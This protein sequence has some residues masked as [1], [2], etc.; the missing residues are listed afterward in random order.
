MFT[1]DAAY[2]AVTEALQRTLLGARIRTIRE[3]DDR[4][5]TLVIGLRTQGQNHLLGFYLDAGLLL[6]EEASHSAPSSP[7]AF[8]MF[9]RKHVVGGVIERIEV[10]APQHTFRLGLRTPQG[11]WSLLF[12]A[13]GDRSQLV[14]LDPS[15]RIL[16]ATRPRALQARGLQLHADYTL[17]HARSLPEDLDDDPSNWTSDDAALWELLRERKLGAFAE[18]QFIIER[19][20]LRK[21]L[22]T[23]QKRAVRRVQNVLRDLERAENADILRHEADLLQSV[24]HQLR[25][26]M[27][28]IDVP[29][30]SSDDMS[31]TRV[32]LDPSVPIHEEI[33]QRYRRYRRMKDAETLILER[34]ETVE[35]Q[36]ERVGE[37][38]QR[39]AEAQ[40][41]EDI[42][43]LGRAFER[44]SIVTPLDQA[45]RIREIARKPYREARSSDGFRVL[46]GR[47]AKDNDT[48]SLRIARGRDLWMHARD[49]PGSHVIIWRE[50]RDDV[51][52]ERTLREAAVLAAHY[53]Q[54]KNDT[55]VDVGYTER[56]HISKAKGAPPGSVQ[57]AAMRTLLVTPDE[58]LCQALF[59]N[60]R[61]H[62]AQA[63]DA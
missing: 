52:P 34:L 46:V 49:V 9:L 18:D 47:T 44:R 11:A 7:S 26:G 8:T 59:A 45:Q 40:T 36:A 20:R 13:D 50:G 54:A 41:L 33:A 63:Q 31:P 17:P 60:A 4:P 23:A 37:A 12:E 61:A 25:R 10:S 57:V 3:R 22:K 14:L 43:A 56:K 29:D 2:H 5:D 6:F 32:A 1:C 53:S 55:T 48:L 30:W 51:I 21:R 39:V 58:A 42:V 27:T 15:D 24:Q 62:R 38:I 19:R 35:A 16:Q 28:H